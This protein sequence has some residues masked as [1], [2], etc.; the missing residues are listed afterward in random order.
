MTPPPG[1][2]RIVKKWVE[3]KWFLVEVNTCPQKEG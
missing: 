1:T 2:A 3:S